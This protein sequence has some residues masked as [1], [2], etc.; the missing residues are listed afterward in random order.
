MKMNYFNQSES[1]NVLTFSLEYSRIHGWIA[2]VICIIGTIFNIFNLIVLRRSKFASNE[3]NTI[4]ASI[5]LCDSITMISYSPF[6]V[7][8]YIINSSPIYSDLDPERDTKYWTLYSLFSSLTCITFHSMSIWLTVYLSIYRCLTIKKSITN[9]YRPNFILNF[10]LTRT[11]T[12]IWLIFLFCFTFCVPTYMYPVLKEHIYEY[13]NT[14]RH[15][16]NNT[17]IRL[18]YYIDQSDLNR[19]KNDLIFK[20]SFYLQAFFGKIIPSGLLGLFISFLLYF[21]I[22]IK[23]KKDILFSNKVYML[24]II[25]ITIIL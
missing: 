2:I 15:N 18:I 17:V 24:M 6:I 9:K 19:D 14:N 3:T 16:N 22:L 5:A 8:F 10:I 25:F 7:H 1:F 20:L 13:D 21:L 11:K 23:R 4:L 12:T